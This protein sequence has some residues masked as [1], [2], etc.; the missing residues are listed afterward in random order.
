[1]RPCR[2]TPRHAKRRGDAPLSA[3]TMDGVGPRGVGGSVVAP[4]EGGAP[5]L[6]LRTES[7][8]GADAESD[9]PKPR[10][11]ATAMVSPRPQARP[12]QAP[13]LIAAANPGGY[14]RVSAGRDGG[15]APR[16]EEVPQMSEGATSTKRV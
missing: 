16:R 2:L 8:P 6:G 14:T 10:S 1:M 7:A 9:P 4:R 11:D 13:G 3:T 12:T 5:V 15:I